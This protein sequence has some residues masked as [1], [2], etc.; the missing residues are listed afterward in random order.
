MAGMLKLAWGIVP[1]IS[2][3]G[4]PPGGAPQEWVLATPPGA[5]LGAWFRAYYLGHKIPFIHAIEGQGLYGSRPPS[6]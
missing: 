2:A 6:F 4:S 5:I 1:P 3:S